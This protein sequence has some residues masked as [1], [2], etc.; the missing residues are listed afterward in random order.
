MDAVLKQNL[1][2]AGV[3]IDSGLERFMGNETLYEKFLKRFC[4]DSAYAD[5]TAAIS[6]QNCEKAFTAAHTLKGVCG[7]LSMIKLEELVK[8]QV[9]FLRAGDL[10]AAAKMMPDIT[11]AYEAV[12]RVLQ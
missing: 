6:E 4:E 5:L 7:N 1:A 12:M 9:E 10:T 8:Q 11:A 2:A 3:E